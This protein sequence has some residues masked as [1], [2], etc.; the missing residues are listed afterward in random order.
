MWLPLVDIISLSPGD[1]WGIT[2]SVRCF[3]F[4]VWP[5]EG[6]PIRVPALMSDCRVIATSDQPPISSDCA[7]V[8]CIPL[9][10]GTI[11]H[12]CC[13]P[14]LGVI[15]CWGRWH[16][17]VCHN[18]FPMGGG[19]FSQCSSVPRSLHN[20]R[21]RHGCDIYIYRYIDDAG[22]PNN[23]N[24]KKELR[25]PS[26]INKDTAIWGW[27]I[28]DLLTVCIYPSVHWNSWTNTKF[29]GR[30]TCIYI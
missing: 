25:F 5:R 14:P 16:P 18:S 4:P 23:V 26:L 22:F 3:L 21:T 8:R 6:D 15:P 2:S 24:K 10:P 20:S 27:L 1:A 29:T 17:H 12:Y 30:F 9:L 7:M 13:W 28:Q 19:V 11:P